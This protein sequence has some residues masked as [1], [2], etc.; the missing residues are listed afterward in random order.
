V[1]D[2]R[3]AFVWR[4]SRKEKATGLSTG[5]FMAEISPDYQ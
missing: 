3:K 1:P 4:C 2:E 5:G